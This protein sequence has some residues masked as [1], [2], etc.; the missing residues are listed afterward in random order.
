MMKPSP[1]PFRLGIIN[2]PLLVY[3][4]ELVPE[5]FD[6]MDW[7]SFELPGAVIVWLGMTPLEL[8]LEVVYE[9]LN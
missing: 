7:F 1:L 4:F 9:L 8:L 6:I 2:W 3:G 5:A